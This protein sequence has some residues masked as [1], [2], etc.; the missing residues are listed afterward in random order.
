[1]ISF[2]WGL[3][4]TIFIFC[5]CYCFCFVILCA[6]PKKQEEV[7][8]IEQAQP[9]PP[10][11]PKPTVYYVTSAPKRKKKRP[12]SNNIGLKG[13][14]MPSGTVVIA[15]P[16]A[17]KKHAPKKAT[18]TRKASSTTTKATAK[19][20]SIASTKSAVAKKPTRSKSTKAKVSL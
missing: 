5:A 9:S 4:L 11:T 12:K 16:D 15:N 2:V 20:S 10:S 17:I 1:M 6:L 14:M 7:K 3:F 13:A 19:T 18:T 8:P